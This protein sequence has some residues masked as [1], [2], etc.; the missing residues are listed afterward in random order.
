MGSK[1]VN[2][3]AATLLQYVPQDPSHRIAQNNKINDESCIRAQAAP[4]SYTS[5]QYAMPSRSLV[6]AAT[7]LHNM[8]ITAGIQVSM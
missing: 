1:L 5:W 2:D 8:I 4:C 7:R 6:I 3:P